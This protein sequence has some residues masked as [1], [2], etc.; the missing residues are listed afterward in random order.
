MPAVPAGALRGQQPSCFD[1][2]KMGF[3]MG[4]AVGC[5]SGALFGG[6]AALRSG[7]RGVE[8]AKNIGKSMAQGGG[9]FGTFM[10]IG[11]GIRC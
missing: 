9:T 8:L 4:C 3:M 5:V 11:T 10:C 6:F 2:M 1:R 7:F